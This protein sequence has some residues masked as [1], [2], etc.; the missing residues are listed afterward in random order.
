MLPPPLE[1]PYNQMSMKIMKSFESPS[2]LGNYS[3]LF[4]S[5]GNSP[6]MVV[7]DKESP[8]IISGIPK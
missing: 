8:I 3:N 6:Q 2:F 1:E 5:V 7:I 4:L